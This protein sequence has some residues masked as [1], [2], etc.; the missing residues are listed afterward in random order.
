VFIAINNDNIILGTSSFLG[1]QIKFAGLNALFSVASTSYVDE[2]IRQIDLKPSVRAATTSNISLFGLQ[3]I[4]GVNVSPGDRVLVK[5]QTTGTLNGIYN[6]G[7]NNWTRSP[8]ALLFSGTENLQFSPNMFFFIEE[9]NT[10]SDTGWT[11]AN[12]KSTITGNA[13]IDGSYIFRQFADARNQSRVTVGTVNLDVTVVA[14]TTKYLLLDPQTDINVF[15]STT[16]VNYG[17]EIIIRN[18]SPTYS[19]TVYNGTNTSSASFGTIN[20]WGQF[21]FDGAIWHLVR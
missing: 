19:I 12:N 18:N 20:T 8:G 6:V 10:Q 14:N 15:L 7:A 13:L 21:V 1:P 11:L 17:K 2:S 16:A 9:G 4:D 5:N 3:T